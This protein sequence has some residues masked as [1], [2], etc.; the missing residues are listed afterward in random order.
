M[1]DE[2][3]ER[4]QVLIT[5]IL[6]VL[7]NAHGI[8]TTP[9]F[10]D[11]LSEHVRSYSPEELTVMYRVSK[12]NVPE[13]AP[14]TM[15]PG[16]FPQES[17]DQI[18]LLM[19]SSELNK[20]KL[21]SMSDASGLKIETNLKFFLKEILP[22]TRASMLEIGK[23]L[24]THPSG[25][26]PKSEFRTVDNERMI[27]EEIMRLIGRGVQVG[28]AQKQVGLKHGVK[29]RSVQRIWNGRKSATN[30]SG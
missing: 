21:E 3:A 25:G 17:I 2:R 6:T 20:T 11:S 19:K 23:L 10:V 14:D 29:L 1:T 7:G 13:F 4:I 15:S 24:P 8:P 12:R 30:S 26:R 16:L 22:D 28:D 18:L 5:R 9:A 27:C